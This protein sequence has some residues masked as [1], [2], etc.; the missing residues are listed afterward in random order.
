MS[1]T[2]V[3]QNIS[4]NQDRIIVDGTIT[5]AGNYTTNGVA[6]DLSHLGVPSNS[7]P[8]V[9]SAWS[10]VNQG[11]AI[12]LDTYNYVPG[13]SQANG[14]L[15]IGVANAEMAAAA[16]AATTPCNAAGFVLHFQAEF[17]A[18]I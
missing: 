10:T 5:L 2:A 15:Q 13:T 9:F 18:F 7:K 1:M 16:F 11:A 14:M 4:K 3:L 12:L 8:T 17:P 6:L